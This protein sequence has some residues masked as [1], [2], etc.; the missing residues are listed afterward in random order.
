M[1]YENENLEIL[2][3]G[4]NDLTED[5]KKVVIYVIKSDTLKTNPLYFKQT[6]D[7]LVILEEHKIFFKKLGMINN[8]K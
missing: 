6:T 2:N 8:Q 1:Q 7:F 3:E 4:V 5:E